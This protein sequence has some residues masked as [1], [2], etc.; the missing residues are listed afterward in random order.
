MQPRSPKL[1]EDIRESADFIR[2]VTLGRTLAE[3]QRD[4]LLRRAVER[5]FEIIGEAVKRAAHGRYRC[6]SVRSDS[7][8]MRSR[9]CSAGKPTKFRSTSSLA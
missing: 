8:T 9:S 4:R 2:E 7:S 3:Y 6:S 5:S 1:L